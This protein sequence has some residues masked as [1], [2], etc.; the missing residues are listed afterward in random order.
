VPKKELN[1]AK[2]QGAVPLLSKGRLSRAALFFPEKNLRMRR[3][4]DP[5]PSPQCFPLVSPQ[6]YRA[7]QPDAEQT[8]RAGG[9]PPRLTIA[10]TGPRP[11]V[12]KAD[13]VS[14]ATE[15]FASWFIAAR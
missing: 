7:V 9:S 10:S 12:L 5:A 1:D 3:R 6:P 15:P 14:L 8:I 2:P 13:R 11:C 4:T